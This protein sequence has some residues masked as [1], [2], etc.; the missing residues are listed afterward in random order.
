MQ[1]QK[2]RKLISVIRNPF[3]RKAFIRQWVAAS[4]EHDVLLRQFGKK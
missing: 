2:I 3:Y 4:V 1:L